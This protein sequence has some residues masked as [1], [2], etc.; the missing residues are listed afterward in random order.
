ME[1]INHGK[2]ARKKN[3]DIN[4]KTKIP[5]SSKPLH[6]KNKLS[7]NGKMSKNP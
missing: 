3:Y 7:I 6:A 2:I 1:W 4:V 5:S